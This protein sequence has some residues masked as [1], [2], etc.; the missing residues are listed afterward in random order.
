[1]S[2]ERRCG[3]RRVL[4]AITLCAA[5]SKIQAVAASCLVL[6]DA[7]ARVAAVEGVRA[8]VFETRSCAHLRLLQGHAQAGWVD[9]DG[10]PR[11]VPITARGPARLPQAT[12]AK[13]TVAQVW[14]QLT[15]T[16]AQQHAA[17]T[18]GI[19]VPRFQD[20][21]VPAA[22][23]ALPGSSAG[24][25]R[26]RITPASGPVART[27]ELMVAPRRALRLRASWLR[28]GRAYRVDVVRPGHEQVYLWRV[29]GPRESAQIQ[30][31]LR[32]LR[33][34]LP[35]ARQRAAMSALV[36]YEMGL[37]ANLALLRT[38]WRQ[39]PR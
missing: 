9:L 32:G 34:A 28:P 39:R 13:G 36:L 3:L 37:R 21:Y 12:R 25:T 18:R 30:A 24:S 26:V 4:Y 5:C 27:R 29:V 6:G 2:T 11:L 17:Y 22:G 16:R 38:Q 15:T 8:P 19:E 31:R 33:N 1:M 10:T 20:L 14:A 23:L 35:D 7:T